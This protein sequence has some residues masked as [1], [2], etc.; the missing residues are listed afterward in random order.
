MEKASS[1]GDQFSLPEHR[2]NWKKLTEQ[3]PLWAPFDWKD[4]LDTINIVWKQDI[5]SILEDRKRLEDAI[6]LPDVN[7]LEVDGAKE[8]LDSHAEK[9]QTFTTTISEI[10][11]GK[12]FK[13]RTIR[14]IQGIG[15][16]LTES[17][18]K[19]LDQAVSLL[20]SLSEAKFT[21][22]DM[23]QIRQ[24]MAQHAFLEI[25]QIGEY[26][27]N[28]YSGS[29]DGDVIDRTTQDFPEVETVELTASFNDP[30]WDEDTI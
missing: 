21:E 27:A 15:Y 19:R 8:V 1:N 7:S 2:G 12:K 3:L 18:R 16:D 6:G 23:P 26:R 25:F 30:L 9:L 17:D 4:T 24:R 20:Q 28:D 5:T 22:E 10:V 14:E 11:S 13:W 29:D